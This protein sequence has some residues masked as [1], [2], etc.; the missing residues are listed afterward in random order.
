MK[1]LSEQTLYEILEV[2]ENAAPSEI[3]KAYERARELYAPG[4]L[5]TYTLMAPEEVALLG[6]RIEEARNVLLD[7]VARAGY[8]ARLASGTPMPR[9]GRTSDSTP[10]V[11]ATV[12]PG[13]QV[14]A[15]APRAQAPEPAAAL[16]SA[17]AP[18]PEPPPVPAA[19]AAPALLATPA[20]TPVPVIYSA[21]PPAAAPSPAESP[22][23][24]PAPA[25][26]QPAAVPRPVEKALV[27]PEGTPW[28]G[29]LLRRV[30]EAR[31]LTVAQLAEK[32]RI[33]RHH[34][35]NV[36]GERF[37]KLPAPVYLRGIVMSIARELRLDGQKVAR[38]Y[39]ERMAAA[40]RPAK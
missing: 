14:E 17:P 26:V 9:S 33:T 3:Q 10:T 28:G 15:L 8:D 13:F 24:V 40:P 20:A 7:P 4:S 5:A 25:A 16:P 21:L 19:A 30:R 2:A 6:R 23:P 12:P 29:E 18:A 34:I 35:E 37:D 39:L 36:E 32:T 1:P 38:S 22:E 31:G 11:T 27:V